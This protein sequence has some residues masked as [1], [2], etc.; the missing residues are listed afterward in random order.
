MCEILGWRNISISRGSLL[1]LRLAEDYI[2]TAFQRFRGVLG[3]TRSTI[4]SALVP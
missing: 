4:F 3:G 1:T 2:M